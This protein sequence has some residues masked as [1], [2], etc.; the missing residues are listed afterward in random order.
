MI[1]RIQSVYLFIAV[2]ALGS[3]L[4]F[5]IAAFNLDT[6]DFFVLDAFG[7]KNSTGEAVDVPANWSV[8]ISVVITGVL[9]LFALIKYTN[10]NLQLKVLRWSY[11]LLIGILLGLYFLI[12]KNAE[13]T[14]LESIDMQYGPS[15]FMPVVAILLVFLAQRGIKK[16]EEL[17][18]SLDRLR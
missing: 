14:G 10:R 8:V 6:P 7:L 16:D 18:K 15:Y 5:P 1:Q 2:L 3:M 17:V 4:V 13:A 11:L 9:L 12:K